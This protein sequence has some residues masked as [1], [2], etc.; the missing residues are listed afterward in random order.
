M[1]GRV[2]AAT[3]QL[4]CQCLYFNFHLCLLRLF[5]Q[6]F[7]DLFV[8][9]FFVL[10]VYVHACSIGVSVACYPVTASLQDC[11]VSRFCRMAHSFF[12]SQMSTN[13]QKDHATDTQL[14]LFW[15]RMLLFFF[16][17]MLL[18]LALTIG[19]YGIDLIMVFI[20]MQPLYL[21][22]SCSFQSTWAVFILPSI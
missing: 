19:F 20:E 22:F 11:I 12:H 13:M 4:F 15:G 5:N 3:K 21:F 14:Q 2:I 6:T 17:L 1:F 9:A 16:R 7:V 10:G 8:V 18:L